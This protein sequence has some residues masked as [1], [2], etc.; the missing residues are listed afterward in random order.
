M[1][2]IN[3]IINLNHNLKIVDNNK[4]ITGEVITHRRNGTSNQYLNEL[5][6]ETVKILESVF[7]NILDLSIKN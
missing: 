7:S 2:K 6:T 3:Y 5:N 1:V 4:I